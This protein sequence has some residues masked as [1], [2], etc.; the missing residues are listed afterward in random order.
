MGALVS[1]A[2]QVAQAAE[3][4][5][6]AVSFETLSF[7]CPADAAERLVELKQWED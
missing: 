6:A 1:R 4:T 5:V 7:G 2:R 3:R